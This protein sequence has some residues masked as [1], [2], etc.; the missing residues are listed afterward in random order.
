MLLRVDER[1]GVPLYEQI[2]A[3]LRRAVADGDVAAG[4]RLP[5][6]KQL[7]ASLDVNMHT[8]LKSYSRLRDEGVV[9]MRRGRGV[10]VTGQGADR[11]E[12][13]DLAEQ[14]VTRARRAGLSSGEIIE[15]L[16]VHL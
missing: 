10:T 16:E 14:L 4:D 2:A 6:A 12:L 7:A 11:A 9:E 5:S 3:G 8:V 13:A 15:M 1:S